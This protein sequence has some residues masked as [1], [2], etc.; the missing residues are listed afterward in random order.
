MESSTSAS[1]LE[2]LLMQRSSPRLLPFTYCW[3]FS[4]LLQATLEGYQ[5]SFLQLP[6]LV[7]GRKM[8]MY[9]NAKDERWVPRLR[10]PFLPT[11]SR[12]GV[13]KF[14]MTRVCPS[15]EVTIHLESAIIWSHMRGRGRKDPPIWFQCYEA[16]IIVL[17]N[18]ENSNTQLL[19]G[20]VSAEG[21]FSLSWLKWGLWQIL[22]LF[23][24][25]A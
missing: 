1:V 21:L 6:E 7:G 12:G 10:S 25:C 19:P 5:Y 17:K 23:T 9:A 16:Y 22:V 2:S 11:H 24:T 4:G 13:R 14:F 18:P 20:A 3:E 8:T 15:T